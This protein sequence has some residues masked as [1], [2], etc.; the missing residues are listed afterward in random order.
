LI[1][2]RFTNLVKKQSRIWNVSG[3]RA[4]VGLGGAQVELENLPAL[5]NGAIAF[6]SPGGSQPANIDD[7]YHL[8]PDLAQSQRGVMISLD[9]PDG[10]N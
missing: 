3:L 9:L 8:Y 6:D 5:V 1:E 4:D 2:R 10:I 7:T